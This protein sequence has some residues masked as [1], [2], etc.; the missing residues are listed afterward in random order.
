M[1]KT[2]KFDKIVN[3]HFLLFLPDNLR[4]AIDVGDIVTVTIERI[5]TSS[6][7]KKKAS[8]LPPSETLQGKEGVREVSDRSENV[9]SGHRSQQEVSTEVQNP[10]N[11]DTLET[12][13][14]K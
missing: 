2:I 4:T 14:E 13:K 6:R 1:G 5:K 3:K 12:P 11:I 8:E 9:E 7:S 10:N